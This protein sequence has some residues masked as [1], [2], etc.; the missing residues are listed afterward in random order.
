MVMLLRPSKNVAATMSDPPK[1]HS[2]W[3]IRHTPG[4]MFEESEQHCL[5]V[6]ANQS[7]NYSSNVR[8]QYQLRP[9]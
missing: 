3:R 4:N 1:M 9:T 7:L 6:K 8:V 2:S 5:I